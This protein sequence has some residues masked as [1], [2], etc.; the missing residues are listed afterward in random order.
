[1]WADLEAQR[2]PVSKH[3]TEKIGIDR[4]ICEARRMRVRNWEVGDAVTW[5][6]EVASVPRSVRTKI[7]TK[8]TSSFVLVKLKSSR[9]RRQSR[10]YISKRLSA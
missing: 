5:P 10:R 8:M 4:G 3:E 2:E 6:G 9:D 1:M 7:K